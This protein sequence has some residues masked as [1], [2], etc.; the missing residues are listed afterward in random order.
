MPTLMINFVNAFAGYKVPTTN[1]VPVD[2]CTLA[3]GKTWDS[4]YYDKKIMSDSRI[5]FKKV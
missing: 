4:G 2:F 1:I 3:P 5:I